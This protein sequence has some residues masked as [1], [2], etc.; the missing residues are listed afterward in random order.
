MGDTQSQPGSV[1]E[2]NTMSQSI[3]NQ[4]AARTKPDV[5]TVGMGATELMASDRRA[6]TIIAINH[7]GRQLTFQRDKA[8]RT[9][10]NGMSDDQSYGYSPNPGAQK[11]VYTRRKNGQWCLQ[12][13]VAGRAVL[14]VGYRREYH[15]YS[16]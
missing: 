14:A 1:T 7:D 15:D 4:I 9:D 3:S 6:G 10:S 11:R 5:P 13:T 2:E 12:G 8:K 16:F